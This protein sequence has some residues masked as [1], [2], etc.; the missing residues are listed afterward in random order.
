MRETGGFQ[1]DDCRVGIIEREN[2]HARGVLMNTLSTMEGESGPLLD[3][4]SN[5]I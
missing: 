3:S 2:A 4:N 5:K 1:A